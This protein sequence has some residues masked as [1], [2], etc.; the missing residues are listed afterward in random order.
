M[1]KQECAVDLNKIEIKD[2]QNFLKC[3]EQIIFNI[4]NSSIAAGDM[5]MLIEKIRTETETANETL[6]KLKI[7]KLS[8]QSKI[9]DLLSVLEKNYKT[10]NTELSNKT[11]Q[12]ST[13][14]YYAEAKIYSYNQIDD[15]LTA[16]IQRIMNGNFDDVDKLT[17]VNLVSL[18]MP[19]A[20]YLIGKNVNTV[21]KVIDET[22]N[23]AINKL[24]TI[25]ANRMTKNYL[26]QVTA[27]TA[28]SSLKY[29][30]WTEIFQ[31]NP[32]A[33]TKFLSNVKAGTI[34]GT[35]TSVL[36]LYLNNE[37]KDM[38]GKDYLYCGAVVLEG[39][40]TGAISAIIGSVLGPGGGGAAFAVGT[41][42]TVIFNEI[43][44]NLTGDYTADNFKDSNGKKYVIHGNG[45]GRYDM[46]NKV[47][48][49][50]DDEV[51]EYKYRGVSVPES[52]YK[53]NLYNNTTE[54][55]KNNNDT[56]EYNVYSNCSKE[57]SDFR[58]MIKKCSDEEEAEQKFNTYLQNNPQSNNMSN[59][60]ASLRGKYGWNIKDY[61]SYTHGNS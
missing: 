52:V 47:L 16:F 32:A 6:H 38:G 39:A 31:K 36:S 53:N 42:A 9:L 41:A 49:R 2:W 50:I 28:S 34:V 37:F 25:I 51:K 44:D 12:V 55:L 35:A 21:D 1:S 24:G 26:P 61:W 15:E 54:F 57:W 30:S 46:S 7:K 19:V 3:N 27:E 23:K 59:Q 40:V 33:A 56:D 17:S 20:A 22:R 29:A 4:E 11:F 10:L 8:K 13:G 18:T 48:G 58:S 5:E 14:L 43:N 60:F 45:A